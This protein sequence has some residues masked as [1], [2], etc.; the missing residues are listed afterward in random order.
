MTTKTLLLAAFATTLMAGTAMATDIKIG[1]L[2]DRSG[3][4]AD[5]SGEGRQQ[6]S[7]GCHNRS[8]PDFGWPHWRGK[9]Y[10]PR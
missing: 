6:Q 4:Y 9:H 2:N 8:P 10:T 7:L 5:L 1:V 3:V